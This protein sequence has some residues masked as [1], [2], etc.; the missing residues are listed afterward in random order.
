MLKNIEAIIF[1]FDGVLCS[2]RF[3]NT[4]PAELQEKIDKD[5]F[6]NSPELVNDWMRGK[7]R[8]SD[9]NKI[10]AEMHNISFNYLE[11]ELEK[12]VKKMRLNMPLFNFAKK[13]RQE[14]FKIGILTDNMDVFQKIFVPHNKLNDYFDAIIS[15]FDYKMFK[16]ENNGELADL[17]LKKLNVVYSKT[18]FIDDKEKIGKIVAAKGGNFYLYK[19][20]Y[21]EKNYFEF[22]NWFLKQFAG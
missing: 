5:I 22:E 16:M 8:S 6:K 12:S 4:L 21:E 10:I 13:R 1:D 7:V 3:Y 18:L 11:R 2:D 9:I 19:K 17:A 15:S 20:G 14:G